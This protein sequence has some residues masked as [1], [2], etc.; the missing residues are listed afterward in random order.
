MRIDVTSEDMVDPR[1]RTDDTS[2]CMVACAIRRAIG[3]NHTILVGVRTAYIDD[4]A[5][6]LSR[7]VGRKIMQWA[8]GDHK[9]PRFFG[10]HKLMPFSFDLDIPVQGSDLAVPTFEQTKQLSLI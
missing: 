5:Y 4:T 7:E 9:Q 3:D 1:G 6:A 8:L 10:R 2:Y